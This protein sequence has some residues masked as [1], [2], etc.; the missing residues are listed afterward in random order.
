MFSIALPLIYEDDDLLVINKPAG[1][2]VIS[3]GYHP[4]YPSIRSLLTAQLGRIYIVHRLDK[5]TSGILLV[6]K[7][8]QAHKFLNNQFENR[9]IHK[10]YHAIVISPIPLP[11]SI[12][13]DRPLKVNGDR[14][15]RTV[16]DFDSGKP[17]VTEFFLLEQFQ[18]AAFVKAFPQSGYTH[19]I[20]AHALAAGFPLLGDNL[21]RLS[22]GAF[23][24]T[25]HLASFQR[26][27]LH[28]VQISFTHPYSQQPQTFTCPLPPD[29]E[30]LL[31]ELRNKPEK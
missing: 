18:S 13:M 30:D 20:R 25:A 16:V 7:T 4:E 26:P 6:A 29:F 3:D 28:A 10:I 23:F 17:A 24:D 31:V 14:R 11:P 19:Q 9:Q 2:R 27:A 1:L 12:R 21:Y 5:D 15:H 8:P 22:S